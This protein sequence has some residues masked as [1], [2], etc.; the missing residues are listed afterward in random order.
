MENI[1]LNRFIQFGLTFSLDALALFC[2]F[3][4]FN[5]ATNDVSLGGLAGGVLY[6]KNKYI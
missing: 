6:Y 1:S 2:I 3:N 5:S 4:L